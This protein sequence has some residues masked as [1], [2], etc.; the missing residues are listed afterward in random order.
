[1]K[2]IGFVHNK[3]HTLN[4][5]EWFCGID[6][7]NKW[8]FVRGVWGGDGT[9]TIDKRNNCR[10]SFISASDVFA[11]MIYEFLVQQNISSYKHTRVNPKHKSTYCIVG[12]SKKSSRLVFIDLL[13]KNADIFMKRKHK[14]ALEIKMQGG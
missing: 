3:T 8:H 11:D 4:L 9:M 7:K 13:Y 2:S 10:I 5:K 14:K 6:P 1:M 12:P